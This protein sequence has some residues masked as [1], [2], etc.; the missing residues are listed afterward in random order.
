MS[1]LEQLRQQAQAREAQLRGDLG[2]LERHVQL[3]EAACGSL[4]RY[5]GD[6][7][8]QLDLLEPASPQRFR[9][10][11]RTLVEGFTCR[12][13]AADI[14]RHK[15]AEGPLAGRELVQQVVLHGVLESGRALDLAK[16]FPPEIEKLEA[17]LAQAGI[18]CP[19]ERVNAPETGRFVEMRY[20]FVADVLVGVRVEPL[21]ESG[22]LR[23]VLRNLDGLATVSASFAA[24][25]VTTAR[26]DELA[27]WWLGEPQR[28]LEGALAVQRS[29]PA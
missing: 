6:L 15:P 28:F 2:H 4:W 21:H 25:E 10:D 14:R 13:I 7:A 12:R 29:E 17:R 16:D 9:F 3:V 11:N 19:G 5:F 26:L 1:F 24:H 18:R 27:K 22:Q 8:R 23:F 20:R